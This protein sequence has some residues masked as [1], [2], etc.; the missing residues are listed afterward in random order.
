MH[1]H[2]Q[3]YIPEVNTFFLNVNA[4]GKRN[5]IARYQLSNCQSR[6]EQRVL[7]YMARYNL[8]AEWFFY[9][10]AAGVGESNNGR[11]A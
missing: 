5:V 3:F 2:K 4:D 8:F 6:T 10:H 1:Q 11:F 9:R 7:V